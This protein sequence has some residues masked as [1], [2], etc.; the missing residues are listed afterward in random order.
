M[1]LLLN[2]DHSF[3]LSFPRLEVLFKFC[4]VSVAE[5]DNLLISFLLVNCLTLISL[6]I[7][8]N[9]LGCTFICLLFGFLVLLVHTWLMCLFSTSLGEKF[10]VASVLG[11]ELP[12][13]VKGLHDTIRRG[14]EQ[15]DED[16]LIIE[17][18][19]A[20]GLISVLL[21]KEGACIKTLVLLIPPLSVYV[22]K[23]RLN[24]LRRPRPM[25]EHHHKFLLWASFSAHFHHHHHRVSS[26]FHGF[27]QMRN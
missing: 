2:S 20:N 11:Q 26:S 16:D 17:D 9:L 1:L 10:F 3:S 15:L 27:N 13:A 22:L 6:C 14:L 7:N 4:F 12:C 21:Y 23:L 5:V 18:Y 25:F 19:L 24:I 8:F